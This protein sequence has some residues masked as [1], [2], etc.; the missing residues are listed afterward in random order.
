MSP[1]RYLHR[2]DLVFLRYLL[3]RFDVLE[4]FQG[5]PRFKLGFVSSSF[6]F[7]YISGLGSV[8]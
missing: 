3:D 6:C 2:M 4:G 5:N 7:H 8:I 1:S